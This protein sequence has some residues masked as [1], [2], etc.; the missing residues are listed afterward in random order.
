MKFKAVVFDM[1]GV[2]IDSEPIIRAAAQ[3]AAIE[4]DRVV[5]DH[6]Y[7]GLLGLPSTQVEAAFMREFGSDFP[8]VDYRHR[9]ER[10]YRGVIED[11]GLAPKPGVPAL[12]DALLARGVPIAVATST[13]SGNAE[14][15]L[16]AAGL[17]DRLQICVT[18]DQVKSGKPAPDIFIL[19]AQR[20]GIA[21]QHCIAVEDSDVGARAAVAAGMHTLLVPDLTPPSAALTS[22]VAEIHGSMPAA[23]ERIL[24]LLQAFELRR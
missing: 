12:L 3:R 5:T 9:F 22:L 1:D 21:P 18:G 4:I 6:F 19:A 14:S 13:R 23:A 2:L 11:R 17:L 20:I 8:L 10:C 7:A 15:A 24:A 16:A